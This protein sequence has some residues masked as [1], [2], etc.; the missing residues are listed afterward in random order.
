MSRPSSARTGWN[1]SPGL[2]MRAI[3]E[4]AMSNDYP[5]NLRDL[6]PARFMTFRARWLGN[7]PE[8]FCA[9]MRMLIHMDLDAAMVS[10]KC[11]TLV[12]GGA[13]DKGRPPPYVE[14]VS[15]K[16]PGA[17]FKVLQS[18]HQMQVQTPDL[19]TE[20]LNEFLAGLPKQ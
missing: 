4:D 13:F 7:D 2:K 11:P 16:I 9:V 8:S 12:V 10:I 17:K 5:Q 14:A 1:A 19:V 20:T 18:G 3:F 6:D 15:R